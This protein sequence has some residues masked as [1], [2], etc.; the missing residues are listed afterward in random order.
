M[1]RSVSGN[2]GPAH[3]SL[4]VLRLRRTIVYGVTLP[5]CGLATTAETEHVG[6]EG[7]AENKVV[8]R[9][10]ATE[11]FPTRAAKGGPAR[12]GK[13]LRLMGRDTRCSLRSL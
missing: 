11:Q 7:A 4:L 2:A 3:L 8:S 10:G 12:V 13:R 6:A 9:P 1:R 5:D